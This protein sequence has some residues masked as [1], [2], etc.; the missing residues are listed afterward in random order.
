MSFFLHRLISG[1]LYFRF[2]SKEAHFYFGSREV[3]ELKLWRV[4][5][6]F[7]D[8]LIRFH[9]CRKTCTCII[10]LSRLN[11]IHL[12]I[13]RTHNKDLKQSLI[14]AGC[15]FFAN[16]RSV[17]HLLRYLCQYQFLVYLRAAAICC[18]W[19]LVWWRKSSTINFRFQLR[20][21]SI[22]ICQSRLYVCAPMWRMNLGHTHRASI[23]FV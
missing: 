7:L 15:C 10:F 16:S 17:T 20:A 5:P 22:A 12:R 9:E 19:H 1:Y 18:L 23:V 3:F 21:D 8:R 14:A 2:T 13:K 4:P 11:W 6:M